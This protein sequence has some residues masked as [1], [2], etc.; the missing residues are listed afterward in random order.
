MP[1]NNKLTDDSPMPFSQHKGKKMQYVPASYLHWFW[2]C[3]D[4]NSPVGEYIR[5]NLEA[6]KEEY[7][8]G[9]WD[10]KF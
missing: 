2:T 8:D 4:K 9:I 7:P 10:F 3:C 6:L 1:E 5:E